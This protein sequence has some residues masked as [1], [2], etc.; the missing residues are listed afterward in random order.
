MQSLKIKTFTAF[1]KVDNSFEISFE[2]TEKL[3]KYNDCKLCCYIFIEYLN[4]IKDLKL[5][6]ENKFL[7]M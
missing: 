2:N 1:T 6:R 3:T 5:Q 4:C 7:C